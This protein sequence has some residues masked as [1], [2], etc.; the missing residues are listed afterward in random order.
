MTGDS[1]R[2]GVQAGAGRAP[3]EAGA[4]GPLS[5]GQRALWYL[6]QLTAGADGAS[7]RRALNAAQVVRVHAA[8]DPRALAAA[9]DLLTAQHPILRATYHLDEAGEP[10]QRV[11]ERV[12][13]DFSFCDAAGWPEDEL[14]AAILAETRRPFDLE[15]GPVMRLSVFQTG[16]EQ[17]VGV[18]AF[19]HI[20]IDLWSIGL[21]T[22]ELGVCYRAALV[23]EPPALRG[24]AR[25]YATFARDQAAYVD[26]EKGAADWRFW[27]GK[28]A[29][30]TQA[31]ADIRRD[32]RVVHGL[33][34]DELLGNRRA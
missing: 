34:I 18:F 20:A 26:S 10:Y 2:D 19:H 15:T 28:L 30:G 9:V 24:E 16:P 25:D 8:V 7:A 33:G 6:H 23:G 4:R 17:V 3:V 5:Y 1:H 29:G 22:Y 13:R 31:W 11:E 27:A 21:L 32:G 12:P 14:N